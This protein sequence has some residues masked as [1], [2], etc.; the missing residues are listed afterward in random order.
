MGG[1]GS[2]SGGGGSSSGGGGNSSSYS[3][4][5]KEKSLKAEFGDMQ[6]ATLEGSDKQVAW[7]EGI[8]ERTNAHNA[9]LIG[10]IEDRLHRGNVNDAI[11]SI[12]ENKLK[13]LQY[14]RTVMKS[15]IAKE[16]SAKWWIETGSKLSPQMDRITGTK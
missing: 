4:G 7:A 10:D 13:G 15:Y 5:D 14:A 12:L 11:K 8:R 9:R 1:R 6:K 2:S 16:K 3:F